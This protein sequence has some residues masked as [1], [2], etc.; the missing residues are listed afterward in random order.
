M[1]SGVLEAE[2]EQFLIGCGLNPG[3]L[4]PITGDAS[5]RRYLRAVGAGKIVMLDG[6]PD[7]SLARFR[8]L[9]RHLSGLG[10][11]VPK[12]FAADTDLGIAVIE[13]FGDDVFS[14]LLDRGADPARLLPMAVAA[15]KAMQANPAAADVDVPRQSAARMVADLAPFFDFYLPTRGV[16]LSPSRRTAL[17][18]AWHEVLACIDEGPQTLV[19][20]DFHAGNI[21][22]LARG[23]CGFLDFQDALI[24]APEYDLVSL[25]EDARR[26]YPDALAA[27]LVSLHAS[28]LAA[29]AR[30]ESE[31]R[32]HA[33]ASQRHARILGIFTRLAVRD[34]K[35][36]YLRHEP[37]VRRQLAA[38]LRPAGMRHLSAALDRIAPGWNAPGA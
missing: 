36:G 8:D 9:A 25:I 35:T 20:R 6:G 23:D 12:V 11:A 17:E 13:D 31:A 32:F 18:K 37:R 14:T 33:V 4:V 29:G 21:V 16:T 26:D 3:V 1:Q 22:L 28:G 24:G 15:L 27:Q 5:Q 2:F 10:V 19:L 30:A 34:G 38:S 7:P